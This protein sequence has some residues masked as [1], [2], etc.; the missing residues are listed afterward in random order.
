MAVGVHGGQQVDPCLCDQA[1]NALVAPL[2]LSAHVLHEVEDQLAAKS[3]VPVH[4]CHVAKLWLTCQPAKTQ[5][6][7]TCQ[8]TLLTWLIFTDT[9]SAHTGVCTH[10]HTKHKSYQ[11]T[12]SVSQMKRPNRLV[13]C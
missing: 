13:F 8:E 12:R 4:P 1:D 2:V 10:T 7:L 6:H 5:S 11:E 3:L 9:H